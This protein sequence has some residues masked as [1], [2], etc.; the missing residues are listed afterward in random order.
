MSNRKKEAQIKNESSNAAKLLVSRSAVAAIV[1][2]AEKRVAKCIKDDIEFGYDLEMIKG[3][4][5]TGS[6]V[7]SSVE[8]YRSYKRHFG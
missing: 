6:Y 4:I 5:K 3:K 8:T 7:G 1:L 2:E